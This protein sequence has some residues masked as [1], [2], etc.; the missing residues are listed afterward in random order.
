MIDAPRHPPQTRRVFGKGREG[1]FGYAPPPV[2][3]T[4]MLNRL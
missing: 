4:K 3:L 1:A 2:K